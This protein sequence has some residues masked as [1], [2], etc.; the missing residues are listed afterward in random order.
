MKSMCAI[1][2][3]VVTSVL[4]LRSIVLSQTL[5]GIS[6]ISPTKIT[7]LKTT[8]KQAIVILN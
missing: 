6:I 3:I 7:I 4:V 5:Y 1:I 8:F 2:F